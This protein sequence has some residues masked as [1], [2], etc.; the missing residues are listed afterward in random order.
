MDPVSSGL[1]MGSVSSL[2]QH[3][4]SLEAWESEKGEKNDGACVQ[5][6]KLKH[7]KVLCCLGRQQGTGGGAE[8]Q[9][10]R[11]RR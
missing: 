1:V 8:L 4:M 11:K 10:Y 6:L 3:L 7:F 9:S 5:R 2:L